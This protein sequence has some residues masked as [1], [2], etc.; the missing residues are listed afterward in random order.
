MAAFESSYK[1][2]LAGVSQQVPRERQPGQVTSL[3]NMLCDPV[4]NLRRRPGN[5]ILLST[6]WT[7]ATQDS[8]NAWVTDIADVTVRI[9]TCSV[10]G[11]VR[12]YDTDPDT[13]TLLAS[14]Q[15][16]YLKAD[17]SRNIRGAAMGSDF[18]LCNTEVL[19]QRV[20]AGANTND[21]R[22]FFQIGVGAFSKE[23]GVTIKVGAT[24]Y[25]S[26]YT[27]PTGTATGDAA[28]AAPEYIVN[29]LI[30]NITPSGGPTLTAWGSACYIAA[31]DTMSV[32]SS[33]GTSYVTTSGSQYLAQSSSLP[34][35][36]PSTADGIIIGTG[37]QRAQVYYRYDY[38]SQSW[39][40]DGAAGSPTGLSGMPI[41]LFQDPA[42]SYAWTLAYPAYEGR[43]SGDDN[44][45]PDPPFINNEQG[46][47]GM[48]TYQGRLVLLAGNQVALSALAKRTAGTA[49]PSARSRTTTLL[50]SALARTAARRTSTV[51]RS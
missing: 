41:R 5:R 30:A 47:T 22:G 43:L 36:L 42:A 7:G 11:E 45:N 40:E 51:C 29:Q 32:T 31:S 35:S 38:A 46:I 28:K 2:L 50:A 25:T 21:R 26:T 23:Y 6:A 39:L 24:T 17:N 37:A 13:P 18:Y 1:S 44:T 33:S 12:V 10:N 27:T 34:P 19:P 8:L 49:A 14:L 20:E 9:V 16:D 48:G 4:T 15:N 3:E